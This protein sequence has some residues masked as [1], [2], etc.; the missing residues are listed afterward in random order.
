VSR[1]LQKCDLQLIYNTIAVHLSSAYVLLQQACFL[2][3]HKFGTVTVFAETTLNDLYTFCP[4]NGA[5]TWDPCQGWHLSPLTPLPV[6]QDLPN[7][8]EHTS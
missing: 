8:K 2:P 3:P 7:E 4:S 1:I 6:Y 5:N